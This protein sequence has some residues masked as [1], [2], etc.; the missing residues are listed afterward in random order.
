MD[1]AFQMAFGAGGFAVGQAEFTTPGDYPFIVPADCYSISAVLIGG[2]GGGAGGQ[3]GDSGYSG[4]G[5]ALRW[6]KSISTTPLEV[7]TV[8]V[9]AGGAANTNSMFG[10][11]GGTTQLMRGST[12]LFFAGGGAWNGNDPSS[13]MDGTTIGGGDGS[14]VNVKGD[15]SIATGGGGAGGYSGN[16]GNTLSIPGAGGAGAGG[17]YG[18]P[19]GLGG[20]VGI[21]GAGAAGTTAG[22]PG[23]A[24]S[25]STNPRF[26]AGGQASLQAGAGAGM[27]GAARIIYGEGRFY[28]ST[29]TLDE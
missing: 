18:N 17:S 11:R 2:G 28:P 29:R 24:T 9:G 20:G 19:G 14:S 7:L 15:T 5:G 13:S 26:G 1:T 16:G 21:W 27:G 25:F 8:R 10:S 6:A 23:S 3:N 4:S 12:V 22:A